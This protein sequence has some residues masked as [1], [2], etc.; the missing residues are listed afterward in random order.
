MTEQELKIYFESCK[1][2]IERQFQKELDKLAGEDEPEE[3]L[4]AYD[5]DWAYD[6]ERDNNL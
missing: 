5:P 3:I 4:G 1:S 2:S 6:N